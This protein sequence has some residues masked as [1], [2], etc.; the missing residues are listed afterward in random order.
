[1]HLFSNSIDIDINNTQFITVKTEVKTMQ[2]L[3][4]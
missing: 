2:Y 4:Q 1:V 3:K